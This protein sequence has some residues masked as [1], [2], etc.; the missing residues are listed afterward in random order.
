MEKRKEKGK[1]AGGRNKREAY[2][3]QKRIEPPSLTVVL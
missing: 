3:E 1:G 2:E